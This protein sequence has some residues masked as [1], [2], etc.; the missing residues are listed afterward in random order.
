MNE[1]TAA[2]RTLP[3]GTRVLVT[4]TSTG[5]TVEV[6]INDRGPFADGRIIDLSYAAGRVLGALGPGVIP[7]RL[8][9]V[10]TPDN[11]TAAGSRRLTVQVAAFATR[12][13]AE[14]LRRD[15]AREG[16]EAA[17]AES[18]TSGDTYYRVRVG[19]YT[20][21]RTAEES[22]RRLANRGHRPVIVER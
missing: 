3:L 21:R 11:A 6:R 2:H 18:D 20:D 9:V 1:L 22:A 10:G 7:V 4:N 14:V 19:P 16:F 17:I 15:L 12:D 8:Q 5:D 13:R